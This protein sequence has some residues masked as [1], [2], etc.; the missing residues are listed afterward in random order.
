MLCDCSQ[1]HPLLRALGAVLATARPTKHCDLAA[2]EAV[3]DPSAQL[4]DGLSGV[5]RAFCLRDRVSDAPGRVR[6]PSE[7]VDAR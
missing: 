1:E 3:Q 7:I 6:G 4:L 2:Q 5:A